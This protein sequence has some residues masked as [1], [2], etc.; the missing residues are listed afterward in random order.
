MCL[1]EYPQR[2]QTKHDVGPSRLLDLSSFKNS[3][4]VRFIQVAAR[5]Q[6]NFVCLSHCWGSPSVR[7]IQTTKRSISQHRKR[8]PFTHLSLTFKDAVRITRDLGQRYLWIDSLCIVQDDEQ[9]WVKEASKMPNI[10]G[11]AMLTLAALK[12]ADGSFGCRM[13]PIDISRRFI[14]RK[15]DI[16]RGKDHIRFFEKKPKYWYKEYGDN[17]YKHGN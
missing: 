8:I 3:H 13:G 7:P 5:C 12:S 17:P 2:A 16:S 10:Y 6:Y 4:D 9:D 15:T 1:D 14:P 11:A